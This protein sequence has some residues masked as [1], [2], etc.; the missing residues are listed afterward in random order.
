MLNIYKVQPPVRRE[1]RSRFEA[2]IPHVVEVLGVSPIEY[3]R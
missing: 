2:V 3:P 1:V